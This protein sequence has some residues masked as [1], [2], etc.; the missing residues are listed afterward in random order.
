MPNYDFDLVLSRPLFEHELDALFQRTHGEVTVGFVPDAHQADHPGHAGCRWQSTSLAGAIMEVIAHVEASSPGLRVLRVE[1]DPLLS[2]RDIAERV[3]RTIESVRLSIKGA[4]GPGNFPA[5]E[6]ST[7][8]HRLW[9]WSQVAVWYGIDDPQIREAG[10]TAR[11][12]NGW[13]ALRDVV[14][15]IA[16]E[17]RTMVRALASAIRATA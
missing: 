8:R 7:P 4:R 1:A 5:A 13:L 10:P 6:T 9:R 14:P 11:A 16:P 2:M 15:Q 12:I 3:G 17:P